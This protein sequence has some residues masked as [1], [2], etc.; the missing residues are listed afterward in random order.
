MQ[1]VAIGVL[2][3]IDNGVIRYFGDKT[4]FILKNKIMKTI[5]FFLHTFLAAYCTILSIVMARLHSDGSA[6]IT[7]GLIKES[8][9]N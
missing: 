3:K 8:I 2:F 7:V 1:M 5:F 9:A 4:Y 6:F